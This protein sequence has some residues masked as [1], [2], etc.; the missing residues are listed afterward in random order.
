MSMPNLT[1]HATISSKHH[2]STNAKKLQPT[3]LCPVIEVGAA[4][5]PDEGGSTRSLLNHF[6]KLC[7]KDSSV[8]AI[9]G[10]MEPIPFFALDDEFTRVGKICCPRSVISRLRDYVDH[11]VP[12]SRLSYLGQRA[13]DRLLCFVRT[14]EIRHRCGGCR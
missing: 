4:Q 14:C 8:V 2:A 9:K 7:A 12:S 1:R 11:Q 3:D 13:S 6:L 5:A 10:D